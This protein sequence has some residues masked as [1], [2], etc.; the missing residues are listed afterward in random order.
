MSLFEKNN[1]SIDAEDDDIFGGGG[2]QS[3]GAGGVEGGGVA[4]DA[5]ASFLSALGDTDLSLG[6]EERSSS[7]VDTG[8]EGMFEVKL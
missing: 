1:F 5:S 8:K 3:G 6:S 4:R 2:G 7:A